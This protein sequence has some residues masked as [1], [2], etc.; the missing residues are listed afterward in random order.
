MDKPAKHV[1]PS[2]PAGLGGVHPRRLA[3]GRACAIIATK[4]SRR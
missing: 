2:D 3:A 1:S 4:D